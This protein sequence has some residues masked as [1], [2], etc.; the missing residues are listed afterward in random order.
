MRLL[1]DI[2]DG[3]LTAKDFAFLGFLPL[4]FDTPFGPRAG[5]ILGHLETYTGGADGTGRI[6]GDPSDDTLNQDD[7]A[8][9]GLFPLPFDAVPGSG[10][11]LDEKDFV[12]LGFYPLPFDRT[13]ASTSRPGWLV[14][15]PTGIRVSPYYPAH[16][17]G[18]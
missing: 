8:F 17:R 7:F 14:Q 13:A 16:V 1:G 9:L 6:L 2:R 3:T 5:R 18:R 12:F 10:G 4:P 11:T 15:P